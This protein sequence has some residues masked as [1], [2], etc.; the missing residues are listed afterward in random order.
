MA[1]PCLQIQ[2]VPLSTQPVLSVRLFGLVILLFYRLK[3]RGSKNLH[4]L[5]YWVYSKA[6]TLLSI[7]EP[8]QCERWIIRFQPVVFQRPQPNLLTEN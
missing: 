4:L 2:P 1:S 3:L 6:Y 5:I 8:F 7:W